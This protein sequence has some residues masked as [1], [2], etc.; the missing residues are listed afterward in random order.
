MKLYHVYTINPLGQKTIEHTYISGKDA[1][2]FLAQIDEDLDPNFDAGIEEEVLDEK[3]RE[4]VPIWYE[5]YRW[6]QSDIRFIDVAT[7]E[8]MMEPAREPMPITRNEFL[9]ELKAGNKRFLDIVCHNQE[10]RFP[11]HTS[12]DDI[13]IDLPF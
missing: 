12:D 7:G 1:E 3:P 10:G 9:Q 13:D 6:E 2:W 8:P 5:Y 11:Y 4:L